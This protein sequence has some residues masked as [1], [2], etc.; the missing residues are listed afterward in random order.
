MA[1]GP[2]LDYG[3]RLLTIVRRVDRLFESQDKV[4]D[5]IGLVDQRLR[6]IEDRLLTLESRE[7]R[8]ITE[9]RSAASAAATAMSSAAPND[10]VTRLTR[11]EMQ[12]EALTK[13]PLSPRRMIS[14]PDSG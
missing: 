11:A 14:N 4:K 9:A 1:I 2:F 10:L 8:L 13:N 6:A 7:D 12:L 5:A 3:G